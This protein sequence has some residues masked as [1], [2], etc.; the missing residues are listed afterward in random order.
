MQLLWVWKLL[1]FLLK[2]FMLN[3][4]VKNFISPNGNS[5]SYEMFL[6]D[7]FMLFYPIVTI[8]SLENIVW[9]L[10]DWNKHV[11]V[12]GCVIFIYISSH[13]SISFNNT[14]QKSLFNPLNLLYVSVHFSFMSLPKHYV[15]TRT[16]CH[17]RHVA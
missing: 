17:Y 12:D 3:F 15:I 6:K 1:C 5:H 10:H 16:V 4:Y 7:I 2:T 14:H 13:L 8:D 11:Q 9:F